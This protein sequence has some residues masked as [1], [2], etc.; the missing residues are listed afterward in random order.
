[1][2]ATIKVTVPV[3]DQEIQLLDQTMQKL[4]NKGNLKHW[5]GNNLLRV[6][7]EQYTN[8]DNPFVKHWQAAR[9][10]IKYFEN[11]QNIKQASSTIALYIPGID[12][13]T[14]DDVIEIIENHHLN[15]WNFDNLATFMIDELLSGD[16]EEFALP[17]THEFDLPFKQA[18]NAIMMNAIDRE[19]FGGDN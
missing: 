14:M 8:Y 6:I 11:R 3:N 19:V 1:M 13:A 4:T 18:H 9:P 12:Q 10:T 5:L 7:S 16:D 17:I 15:F 2:D